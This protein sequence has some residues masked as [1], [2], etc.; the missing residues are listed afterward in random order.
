M[1]TKWH[2]HEHN[3]LCLV[4]SRVWQDLNRIGFFLKK[5]QFHKNNRQTLV[6]FVVRFNNG[7]LL[8]HGME[9]M[10]DAI[11]CVKNWNLSGCKTTKNFLCSAWNIFFELCDYTVN[12]KFCNATCVRCQF[13]IDEDAQ[14]INQK[15]IKAT[16]LCVACCFQTL[17]NS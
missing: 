15:H 11:W 7:P 8:L 16:Q 1:H 14:D 5:C 3:Q 12:F 6:I 2:T 10:L 4:W 17:W 13:G 9:S